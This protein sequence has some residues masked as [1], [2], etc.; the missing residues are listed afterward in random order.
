[1]EELKQE[2]EQLF[3]EMIK[4]TPL[5]GVEAFSN[6]HDEKTVDHYYKKGKSYKIMITCGSDFHGKRKLNIEIGS[7]KG[8]LNIPKEFIE[9][10][11]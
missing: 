7:G 4:E 11:I 10:W 9:E 2:L 6:Y 1:M 3:D 8:S 5:D